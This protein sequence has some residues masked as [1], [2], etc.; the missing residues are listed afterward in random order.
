MLAIIPNKTSPHPL[1]NA[2][3]KEVRWCL[4]EYLPEDEA[5]ALFK[6]QAKAAAPKRLQASSDKND[7]EGKQEEDES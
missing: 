4:S 5:A 1:F 2:L 7:E 6:L 3:T